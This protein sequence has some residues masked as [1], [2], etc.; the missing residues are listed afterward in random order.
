MNS[1]QWND[2]FNIGVE[3]VD[4]AH[5]RLFSIVGKMIELNEDEH[6]RAHACRETIKYFKNYTV[7][8]FSE[9]EAYM[10]S[11][12]YEK[13]EIHKALHDDLR[14][15]TIPALEVELE[16][17]NYSEEAVQHFLG[18][19]LGWL[20]GHIMMTDRAIT[21]RISD[22]WYINPK[23]EELMALEDA[24]ERVVKE[25][26]GITPRIVSGHYGGEDFGKA[27]FIRLSYRD[28]QGARVRVYMAFEERMVLQTFGELLGRKLVRVDKTVVYAVNQL[29]QM[30]VKRIHFNFQHLGV[31][32]L[33]K[34]N[35]LSYELLV[36]EFDKVP[37][38]YSLLYDGE[39]KGYFVFA[40]A[41]L[42]S[43]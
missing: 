37:I 5:Q 2:R 39:G 12:G 4:K 22:R 19:C 15:K 36:K 16:E 28:E 24:I 26:L 21:G 42:Q 43:C 17:Q 38:C 1:L 8:H 27:I 30:M 33:E 25:M 7:K 35:V 18:I 32:Q 14:D 29:V 9:E 23:Q 6:K 34:E 40:A 20:S 31:F 10:R 11:I 3:I 13:Y 41:K